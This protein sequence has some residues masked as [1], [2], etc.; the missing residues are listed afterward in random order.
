MRE[1]LRP[2]LHSQCNPKLKAPVKLPPDP[3]LYSIAAP[4]LVA[5]IGNGPLMKAAPQVV[6]EGIWKRVLYLAMSVPELTEQPDEH[7]PERLPLLLPFPERLALPY[8]CTR[9]APDSSFA[10]SK[11]VAILKHYPSLASEVRTVSGQLTEYQFNYDTSDSEDEPLATEHSSQ[12]RPTESSDAVLTLALFS[13]T[14]KLPSSLDWQVFEEMAKCCGATLEEF[15]AIVAGKS[16]APP[17]ASVFDN[18][19]VSVLHPSFFTVLTLMRLSSLRRL[20]VHS[21]SREAGPFLQEHGSKLIKLD[22]TCE[23]LS[24]LHINIFELCPNLD[25][26]LIRPKS[27]SFKNSLDIDANH[28]SS[29]KTA[30]CSLT[31]VRIHIVSG[32]GKSYF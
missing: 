28:F 22:V 12:Y 27:R 17:T 8:Y 5:A 7:I 25:V 6:Q 9:V 3:L 20:L 16:D 21:F 19:P 32:M 10:T 1:S 14:S 18:L 29:D 23:V 2:S 24:D 31:K 4:Q 13:R 26:I 11:F 15:S 30:H